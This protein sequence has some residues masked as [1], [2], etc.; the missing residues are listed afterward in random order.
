MAGN[1]W[2]NFK[3]NLGMFLMDELLCGQKLINEATDVFLLDAT[4]AQR[5][6]KENE[7][8]NQ[9]SNEESSKDQASAPEQHE[10]VDEDKTKVIAEDEWP[11]CSSDDSFEQS[12]PRLKCTCSVLKL[13]D[14]FAED[15]TVLKAITQIENSCR[16]VV[17]GDLHNVITT[18]E[19]TFEA[20][21]Q[22]A[23][24]IGGE[25]T[26]HEINAILNRIPEGIALLDN[27]H[28][29]AEELN[30]FIQ[31]TVTEELAKINLEELAP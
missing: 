7:P 1:P 5:V 15:E 19:K 27:T 23:S 17:E 13:R 28:L 26:V 10:V 29:S 6:Q 9:E 30:E 2:T 22:I 24:A 14:M 20:Y 25:N 11:D 8:L 21:L 12:R 18:Y 16:D 4:A 3:I 31:Q